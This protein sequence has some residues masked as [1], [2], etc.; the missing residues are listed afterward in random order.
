[1]SIKAVVTSRRNFDWIAL[2]LIVTGQLP[3]VLPAFV[4]AENLGR[5][6]SVLGLVQLILKWYRDQLGLAGTDLPS[7][8]KG[9]GA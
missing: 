3:T 8:P 2:L 5:I 4:D 1:M 6:V 7:P 9:P